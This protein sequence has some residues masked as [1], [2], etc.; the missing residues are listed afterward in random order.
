HTGIRTI[1]SNT[2]LATDDHHILIDASSN[3]V[4]AGLQD[5]S[6]SSIRDGKVVRVTRIDSSSNVAAVKRNGTTDQVLNGAA[7][8]NSMTLA[9]G[10]TAL[11]HYQFASNLWVR[12]I[13]RAESTVE[14]VTEVADSGSNTV[15][16]ALANDT[17]IRGRVSIVAREEGGAV[18]TCLHDFVAYAISGTVTIDEDVTIGTDS[19]DVA[20]TISDDGLDLDFTADNN[21]GNAANVHTRIV[22]SVQTLPVEPS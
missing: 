21:S 14:D 18:H 16:I 1:T 3:N 22:Y 11:F 13:E 5:G 19:A 7:L 4:T 17:V 8:P 10:E 6:A 15:S 2:N 12:A 9:P 20:L